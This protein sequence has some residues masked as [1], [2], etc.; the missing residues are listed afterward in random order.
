MY[1]ESETQEAPSQPSEAK[2]INRLQ[3]SS[4]LNYQNESRSPYKNPRS[5]SVEPRPT[6]P[7]SFTIPQTP[8]NFKE[9]VNGSTKS[10]FIEASLNE[11]RER[12]SKLVKDK[13]ETM[14]QLKANEEDDD[15]PMRIISEQPNTQ[16]YGK[17]LISNNQTLFIRPYS[18]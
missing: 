12:I 9:L 13:A 7:F 16:F 1:T 5:S 17:Y 15:D 4:F 11:T 6:Q 18:L 10:T 2:I 8:P 3:K 14:N